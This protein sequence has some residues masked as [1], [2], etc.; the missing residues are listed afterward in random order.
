MLHGDVS[1][2]QQDAFM[3]A[4]KR[5]GK[6]SEFH[7]Y[8]N[9]LQVLHCHMNEQAQARAPICVKTAMQTQA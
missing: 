7:Q 6:R 2:L 8:P 9:A 4:T 5:S 3:V 1:L